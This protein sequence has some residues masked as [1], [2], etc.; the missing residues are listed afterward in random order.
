[1]TK[2]MQ[3]HLLKESS[4]E[5]TEEKRKKD[6]NSTTEIDSSDGKITRS[7]VKELDE[8]NIFDEI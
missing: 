1:M 4:I 5:A 7:I 2:V 8:I 3:N 6:N